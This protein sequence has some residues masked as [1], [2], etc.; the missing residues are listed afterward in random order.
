VSI[1]LNALSFFTLG[2][3]VSLACLQMI[4]T[5]KY[6]AALRPY[7]KSHPPVALPPLKATVILCL[8]GSDPFLADCVRALLHQNY[9][10]YSIQIIVDSIADPAWA[11]VH[12]TLEQF[13]SSVEVKVQPLRHPRSTCSLKCSAL[14][15][16]TGNLDPDCQVVALIDADTI[17]H[18]NWLAELVAPLQKE[19]IG[20]T[21]GA[22]WYTPAN[23]QWGTLSRYIWN[24]FSL[25]SMYFNQIPWGG[26]L[27]CRT[28]LLRLSAATWETTLC[29]DVPL[30]QAAIAQ[31]LKIH[32]VPSL[33]MTNQEEISFLGF[34]SWASRQLLLTRLY[35]PYWSRMAFDILF[36]AGLVV[37]SFG[38]WLTA[39]VTGQSIIVHNL[40]LGLLIY[41]LFASIVPLFWMDRSVRRVLIA[42][43]EE[44]P[45]AS[46]LIEIKIL[47]AL[48][49]SYFPAIT[50]AISAMRTK[51]VKWRGIDY[52]VQSAEKVRLVQYFP[53]LT[54][55]A[56]PRSKTSI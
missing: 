31:G 34:H 18:P 6:A 53:Y 4:V 12:H 42:R 8:R 19:G 20:I 29:E 51:T 47:V 13:G 14:L 21:T 44:I 15:Q 9:S 22:R 54:D 17:A 10:D 49:F 38:V 16:A 46:L 26:T 1:F 25:L 40:G 28:S 43:G 41:I 55:A 39:W 2:L 33:I 37:V 36:S 56:L 45:R 23:G 32:F 24:S 30:R 50:I 3:F 5:R 7:F 52:I 48:M 11:I 27:A 35:H